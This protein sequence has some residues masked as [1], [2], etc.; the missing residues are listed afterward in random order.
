MPA[1]QEMSASEQKD[2][3]DLETEFHLMYI[4]CGLKMTARQIAMD[5]RATI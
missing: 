3:E 2:G 4:Y 1:G 5:R